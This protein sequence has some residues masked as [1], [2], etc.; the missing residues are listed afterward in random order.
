M[1]RVDAMFTISPAEFVRRR[2]ALAV[3]LRA[4]AARKAAELVRY[5]KD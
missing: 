4:E 5:L 1:K 2:D 3:M